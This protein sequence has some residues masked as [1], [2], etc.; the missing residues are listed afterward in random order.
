MKK[1]DISKFFPIKFTKGVKVTS[2]QGFDSLQI[3]MESEKEGFV[4]TLYPKIKSNAK[5]F[6]KTTRRT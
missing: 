6:S 3:N 5:S 4:Q 1:R 2:F